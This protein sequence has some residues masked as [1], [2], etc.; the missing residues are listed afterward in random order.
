MKLFKKII[1]T[2]FA[3]S[4]A[5]FSKDVKAQNNGGFFNKLKNAVSADTE[6]GNYTFKDGSIYT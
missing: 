6:I 1:Y 5:F 4:F 2:A 3:V